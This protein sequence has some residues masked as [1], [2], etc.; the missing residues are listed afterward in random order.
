LVL[1]HLLPAEDSVS[2]EHAMTLRRR[3]AEEGGV[4]SCGSQI[5][6][7]TARSAPAQH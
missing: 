6:N 7:D 3:R 4:G 2:A 5:G 1:K